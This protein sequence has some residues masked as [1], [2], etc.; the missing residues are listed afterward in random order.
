M[1]VIIRN[2]KIEEA[3]LLADIEAE[4]FPLRRRLPKKQFVKE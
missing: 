4:C 3:D 1:N 2:A